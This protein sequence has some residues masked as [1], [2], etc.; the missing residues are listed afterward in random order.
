PTGSWCRSASP[1][2][3]GSKARASAAAST[4]ASSLTSASSGCCAAAPRPP[5]AAA[6]SRTTTLHADRIRDRLEEGEYMPGDSRH[7]VLMRQR[8]QRRLA[9]GEQFA[10]RKSTRLN[11]SHGSI[12]Y[13]VFCLK[14]K[15]K[16]I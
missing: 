4:R 9:R 2:S 6:P 11:S 1:N 12:S 3:A 8:D 16:K 14:K 10:D 5:S 13:A 15:K 7:G